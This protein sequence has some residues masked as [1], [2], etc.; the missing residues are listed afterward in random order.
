MIF[1]VLRSRL[2][3]AS[4]LRS[5][6]LVLLITLVWS[7]TASCGEIHDAAKAGDLEKVKALLKENPEMAF[8]KG[9]FGMTPLH[10]AAS[11]GYKDVVELLLAN[12]G[13]INA[14]DR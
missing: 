8:I 12:K 3:A 4:C 13:E 2:S 10:L 1:I 5:L 6:A 11:K 9:D 14:K 7:I